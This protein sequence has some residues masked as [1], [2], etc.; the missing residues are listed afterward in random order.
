MF[1]NKDGT[2]ETA[3]SRL[4]RR[5]PWLLIPVIMLLSFTIGNAQQIT[6]TLSGTIT[7]QTDARVPGAEVVVKNEAT[8]DTRTTKADSAGFWSVTA[9]VPGT[10]TVTVTAK[11]FATWEENQILLNQGDSRTIPS[12]RLKIGSESTAVTVISGQDAEIPVDTAEVSATL[13]NELVDT[14]TLTGRNAAELIKMMPGVT[15]NNAGGVGGYTST[16]TGTNNGPA[17][18]FSANG[19]QPYG[20]T[21][22]YLDGANLI[23]PGNAGTQVANINQD[24]TDSVKYLSASY[25]AEYA[26]GPAVLQAF[27]KSG[28]QKFHG[29]GYVY[30]RD[31]SVGFANDWNQK[32]QQIGGAISAGSTDPNSA[33][34][35]QP[36]YYYYIGGN[37]GGPIFFPHFNHNRDKLFFWGG[38]EDMIQHPYNAPVNMN[39]PTADQIA[40]NFNNPGIPVQVYNPANQSGANH[41][42]YSVPCNS[43]VTWQGCD[44]VNSPWA[45]SGGFNSASPNVPNLTPY[46]DPDGVKVTAINPAANQT[47]NGSNGWNNFGITP[48]TPTDRWEATGKVTY[49]FSDNTKIWGSYA[50]QNETD[51]HP[52]SIWWEP[53]YAIPYPGKPAG[54][55]TAN[56]Y[57]LNF[58]HAFS[59]TTTNEVVFAYS[60]FVNANKLGDPSAVSRTAL[61]VATTGIFGSAHKMNQIPDFFDNWAGSGSTDIR[62]FNFDGGIYGP[63]SFGK[64]SKAPSIADTFTKIIRAH[65]V[66]AG[67]YWDA[68]ENLQSYGNWDG[69]GEFDVSP[70]GNNSTSN[71]VLDRLLGRQNFYQESISQPVPDELWHQW[72]I[73][74]QD[75]W[76]ATRKLTLNIGLRAD[77]MGQWYDKLGGTQVWLPS[78]YIN[79]PNP[80]ANTGLAWNEINKTVPKSG[81]GSELLTWN[82]RLG[83]AW[84]MRGNGQTV[85]RAGFGTYRY[86]VSDNDAGA[87]M[88]GPLGSFAFS[89]SGQTGASGFYG[90]D[91]ANGLVYTDQAHTQA[92]AKQL[93]VPSGL[94]QNGGAINADKFGDNKVPFADTYSF[95]VAQALPSHTVM[96]ISYV[97]S[98]SRNQL[99]NGSSKLYDANPVPI[100]STFL[101]I[102]NPYSANYGKIANPGVPDAGPNSTDPAVADQ[103]FRPL[104]NYQTIAIYQHGGYANYNSLQV[105]GQK[106]SGNLYMFTNFTFGKVL[107]TRDGSTSNGNG[108]GNLV[109]PFVLANNYGQLGYDHT[110]VFNLSFT[111]K[112][113]K[114]VHNNW[115]LGQVVNGWEISNYTTYQDGSPYQSAVNRNMNAVY[116]GNFVDPKNPSTN[117]NLQPLITMPNGHLTTAIGPLSW[118]GTDEYPSLMPTLSCDPRKH[119]LKNQQFNPNCFVVPLPPTAGSIG[120]QGQMVW[121]YIR[122]PHYWGSDLALFKAFRVNDSQRFEVRVSA[123]NWLNHP[124][125][126]FSINGTNDNELS[127]DGYSTA[128][129]LVYNTNSGTTGVPAAKQGYRWM[130]FAGKYYF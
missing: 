31:S 127:F 45:P 16:T 82:P 34:I 29:E 68:Q 85:I 6:G 43:G 121:P 83:V 52:L 109:D 60:K 18:S 96:E 119:L 107:G 124:N 128:E 63:N 7:D 97:G 103:D 79:T 84:D 69:N 20:S 122:T 3:V 72:S 50:Y 71:V 59:A 78:T 56:V 70:W 40:G 120:Q 95:G 94:N 80:P 88:N 99:L 114:P 75:S 125:A 105:S 2:A 66:K 116:N 89:T 130:Q 126:A 49:A 44:S 46:F 58:T 4:V 111:Y 5:A 112:L 108:N 55:E 33:N 26:K 110:K 100:G 67:F 86:Q 76:K 41:W 25:G 32:S 129:K 101:P 53:A 42:A 11:S 37:I 73:W 48:S 81:W 38:Y 36:S 92:K 13:N 28:G 91:V 57:L 61:G 17:G 90:Y 98:A 10:Y 8:N 1:T 102:T 24:M 118:F 77:H 21:D 65:S 64:T 54:K 14:A 9:L 39:V 113:P 22:V 47:P 27:S 117:P 74:G 23:D 106:Q 35:I 93:A 62:Q 15:F 51:N 30:A 123:T 104:Y 12:M 87:A 115:A 19:T